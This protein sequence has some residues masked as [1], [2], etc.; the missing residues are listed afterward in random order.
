MTEALL[1]PHK[2]YRSHYIDLYSDDGVSTIIPIF[3]YIYLTKHYING[4]NVAD[5]M[6]DFVK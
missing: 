3:I 6:T 4:K 1:T 2:I 5:Y